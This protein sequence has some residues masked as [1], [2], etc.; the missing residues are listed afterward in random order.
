MKKYG[1]W[2]PLLYVRHAAR[3]DLEQLQDLLW[4]P[5]GQQL[6]RK[7]LP[8]EKRNIT[9]H[10]MPQHE[11]VFVACHIQG[12]PYKLCMTVPGNT[13]AQPYGCRLL[14]LRAENPREKRKTKQQKQPRHTFASSG[15]EARSTGG[16]EMGPP[17][18]PPAMSVW[19]VRK[20]TGDACGAEG[21]CTRTFIAWF[22]FVDRPS[23][24]RGVCGVCEHIVHAT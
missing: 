6:P 11:R 20:C 10:L 3:P 1:C 21:F 15:R 2:K 13:Q 14:L 19:D 18:P 9:Q 5:Q 23:P 12:T 22:V 7:R 24:G 16:R 17:G 4:V 8:M